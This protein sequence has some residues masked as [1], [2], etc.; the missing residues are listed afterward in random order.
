MVVTTDVQGDVDR[1]LDVCDL[2]AFRAL[3]DDIGVPDL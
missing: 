1:H 3:V 2:D